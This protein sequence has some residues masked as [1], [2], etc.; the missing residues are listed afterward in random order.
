MR[1]IRAPRSPLNNV[2]I[3][4]FENDSRRTALPGREAP[5]RMKSE[6]ERRR[7]KDE[8]K[9]LPSKERK[10][11]ARVRIG[12]RARVAATM[13]YNGR[14]FANLKVLFHRL[15]SSLFLFCSCVHPLRPGELQRVRETALPCAGKM[16]LTHR[17]LVNSRARVARRDV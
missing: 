10:L 16:N 3:R 4:K 9:A 12:Q 5:T 14:H 1:C 15:L 11:R 17:R 13:I 7:G 2:V 8:S 6:K